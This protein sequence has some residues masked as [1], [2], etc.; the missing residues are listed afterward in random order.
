MK[1]LNK[2]FVPVMLTPFDSQ[3]V[4]DYSGLE[5]LT[6]FYLEAGASALFANCLSSEMFALTSQERLSITKHIVDVTKGH[7]PVVASGTFEGSVESQADFVKAIYDT[8][9]QAVIIITNMMAKEDESDVVF[10]DRVSALLELTGQIP[11][12]F[13]ECPVPYKRIISPELL[14]QFISTERIIYHKD[15]SLDIHQVRA[16]IEA[17]KG[18][19][20]GLYD[21]YMAHAVESLASGAAGLSCI[22]GNYFPELIVWLCENYHIPHLKPEIQKLQQFLVDKMEIMHKAYPSV[23]KYYLQKRGLNISTTTRGKAE[24]F[25]AEVK[26]DIDDFFLDCIRLQ[27]ELEIGLVI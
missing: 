5:Q 16:K 7:V 4:I 24:G 10:S 25:T 2:G 12:G 8:G 26:K 11:L 6:T 20:F 17:G 13:Y 19:R 14:G 1:E 15:T 22:Q 18:Y 27:E 3:G 23:A 21:A 9:V